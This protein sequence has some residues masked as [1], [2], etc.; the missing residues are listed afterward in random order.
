[1]SP[2]TLEGDPSA[3]PA[4]GAC[5]R[6]DILP[7]TTSRTPG[8]GR[9][10][11]SVAV[12]VLLSVVM[13]APFGVKKLTCRKAGGAWVGYDGPCSSVQGRLPSTGF[14]RGDTGHGR[15]EA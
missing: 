7:V 8:P 2:L 12:F 14:D 5:T 9:S 3:S 6:Y 11:G 10:H 1:M 15:G 13:P 4:D